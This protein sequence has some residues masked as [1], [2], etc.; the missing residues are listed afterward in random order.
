MYCLDMGS[1]PIVN[2]QRKETSRKFAPLARRDSNIVKT[3]TA[4]IANDGNVTCY[5]KAKGSI[6]GRRAV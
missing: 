6:N 5:S 1:G 4:K 2:Q 3:V